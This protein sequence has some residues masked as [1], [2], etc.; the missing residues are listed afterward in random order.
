MGVY[1]GKNKLIVI[2]NGFDLAHGFKTSYTDFMFDLVMQDLKLVGEELARSQPST[3]FVKTNEEFRFKMNPR[4]IS[5]SDFNEKYEELKIRSESDEIDKIKELK[6]FI[7][8]YQ[9][10][11]SMEMSHNHLFQFLFSDL[12][13]QNWVDI[14]EAYYK[15]VKKRVKGVHLSPE[16]KINKSGIE[17]V[18]KGL[19][20][21]T[22]KLHDFLLKSTDFQSENTHY[23]TGMEKLF[24]SGN[25][26]KIIILNF[27]YT[28]TFERYFQKG[29]HYE[30]VNIHGTLAN[31][32]NP[33]IFGVGDENHSIYPNI[34]EAN[35]DELLVNVKSLKYL[36]TN[37]YINLK[38]ELLKPF[39]VEIIGHSCGIS[40][41]TLLKEIY[42]KKECQKISIYHH[43]GLDSY[44]SSIYGISRYFD[45][46]YE[47]RQK[48]QPF[49][50]TLH[51]PQ[52]GE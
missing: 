21:L 11:F 32:L 40:D 18:N 47:M 13:L 3:R 52:Q 46:N 45:N 23:V 4:T 12:T 26:E 19:H 2:G 51:I 14:E 41:R 42:N 28:N 37:N 9:D 36:E 43:K 33:I 20:F 15:Q 25:A 35:V 16:T 24:V 49:D 27:N 10:E 34:V 17:Q 44:R 22:N 6:V 8:Q 29:T 30:I 1:S 31:S 50:S 7:D 39:D 48:V 5:S 38:A